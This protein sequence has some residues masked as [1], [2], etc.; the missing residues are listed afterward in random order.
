MLSHYDEELSAVKFPAISAF[1]CLVFGAS[2]LI[3]LA[4]LRFRQGT[5]DRIDD[6]PEPT[7]TE[8]VISHATRTSA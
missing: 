4:L 5:T 3:A 7:R 2:R 8:T 6:D 1:R